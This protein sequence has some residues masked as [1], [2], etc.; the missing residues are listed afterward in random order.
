MVAIFMG[1][2]R[3]GE[4]CRV[5]GDGR[6]ERDYVFVGDVVRAVLAAVDTP[7][8]GVFNVGTGVGTSVLQLLAICAAAAGR[9]AEP[10]FEPQRP[11]ELQ[12]SVLEPAL[13][14]Q[15]LGFRAET[16]LPDGARATWV[17]MEG[18]EKE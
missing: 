15:L 8:A 14:A 13:A 5:F 11:G 1:R 7:T 16:S 2:L 10:S 18:G 9:D 4:T 17:W 6:Q 3:D 12:R